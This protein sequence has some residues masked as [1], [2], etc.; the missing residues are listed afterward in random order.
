MSDHPA[1]IAEWESLDEDEA[2]H[3]AIDK[4]GQDPTTSVAYCA[5]AASDRR[6]SAEYRFWFDLFL[7]L[8][9]ESHFGWA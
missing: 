1:V 4:F 3:A 9:D 8:R 6:D 7:S 2:V 5:L